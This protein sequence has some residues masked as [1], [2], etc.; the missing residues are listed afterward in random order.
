M[1]SDQ[2]E[3]DQRR[4]RGHTR[5]RQEA[6]GSQEP[7]HP[8]RAFDARDVLSPEAPGRTMMVRMMMMMMMMTMMVMMMMMMISNDLLVAPHGRNL[9]IKVDSREIEELERA[10]VW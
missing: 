6:S 2:F 7:R 9:S 4:V 1:L 10:L 5:T 3:S 8:R